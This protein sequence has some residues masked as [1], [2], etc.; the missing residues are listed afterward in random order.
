VSTP[1]PSRRL[2][3]SAIFADDLVRELLSA[4][5]VAVLSTLEPDG[6]VHA[7]PMWFSAA[8]GQ[9]LLASGSASRKLRNLERDPRATLVVHDSRAG[10]EVCGVSLRGRV[11]IVRQPD[12]AD[13]IAQVHRRYI[14]ERGLELPEVVGFLGSDDVA[15]RFSAE[16]ADTWDQRDSPAARA[17]SAAGEALPLEPTTPR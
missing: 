7:V 5:L 16:R 9:I 2:R 15:L 8:D 11:E 3:G 13:L 14:T 1:S 6:A 4:R 17:V 12:A 10:C